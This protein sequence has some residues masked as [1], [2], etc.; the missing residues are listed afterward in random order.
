MLFRSEVLFG[1]I[2]LFDD[3][4]RTEILNIYRD[5]Y[6]VNIKKG[7]KIAVFS[8]IIFEKGLAYV[9]KRIVEAL[10]SD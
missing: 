6:F 1:V 4:N 7:W 8:K 5:K 2:I 10:N 3:I 9:A